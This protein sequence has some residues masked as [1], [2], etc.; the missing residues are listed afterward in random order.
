MYVT[1]FSEL[2]VG[3]HQKKL[4]AGYVYIIISI[5]I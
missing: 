3:K 5:I 4:K 2:V 1:T